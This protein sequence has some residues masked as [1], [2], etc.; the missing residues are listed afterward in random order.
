MMCLPGFSLD[1]SVMAAA[2]EPA[3]ANCPDWQRIYVD[4]P[5]CGVSRP[6][7]ETSDGVVEAVAE[8][9]AQQVPSARVLLAGCSYGGCIAA[10]LARHMPTASRVCSWCAAGSG[11]E[12][13]T[14][15]C[16]TTRG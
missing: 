3:L 16:Q 2:L 10:A 12:T 13:R 15:T 4:L 5:G 11:S 8:F 1:R 7:P 9:I 6:G 14:A